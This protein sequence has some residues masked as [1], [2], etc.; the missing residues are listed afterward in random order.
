MDSKI[1]I[2][3]FEI[4]TVDQKELCCDI[5]NVISCGND[6]RVCHSRTVEFPRSLARRGHFPGNRQPET[7]G[8]RSNPASAWAQ[9]NKPRCQFPAFAKM[10]VTD[11]G[12]KNESHI[13]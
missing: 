10:P 6:Y 8:R 5:W 9:G 3:G 13:G 2:D 1:R 11:R 7:R 12:T 4:R